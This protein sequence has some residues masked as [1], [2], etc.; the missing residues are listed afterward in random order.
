MLANLYPSVAFASGIIRRASGIPASMFTV[1]LAVGRAPGWIAHWN[2]MISSSYK[3]G[4]PRQL[5]KGATKR[6]YPT[7]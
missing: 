6:D 3:I 7:K 2:E 1:F 5:Y 4:R